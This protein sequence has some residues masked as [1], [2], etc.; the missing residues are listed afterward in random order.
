MLLVAMPYLGDLRG[1]RVPAR[2]G[3]HAMATKKRAAPR[4][5]DL[6]G[7]KYLRLLGPL[8][9]GLHGHA[10]ARDRAGNRRLHFDQLVSL[11]LLYFFSPVLTSLR[12]L[13]Q[14]SDLA[15][16]QRT[17]GVPRLGLGTLSEGSRAFDP[18]LLRPLLGTLAAEAVPVVAGRE[19][20]A[21]RQLTAVDGSLLPALPRMAWALWQDADHRAAKMHVQF[22]VLKGVPCDATVTTGNGSER[23]QLR[24]MLRPGRLYVIDRGYVDYALF[25]DILEAGSSFIGRVCDDV[26]FR[27][28]E[29]RP[30]TAEATSAGVIRD[31]VVSRLGT[32]HHKDEL[33][34]AVRLVLVAT[35]KTRPDGTAEVLILCTDRLDL[36]AELVALGYKFRWSVE[37]FFRWLKCILGCRHLLF[38]SPRGVALQVYVALIASVLVSLWTGHKPTKRTYE[39]L[40]FYF[41]GMASLEELLAHIEKL[42][43]PP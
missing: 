22:E 20:E 33:H 3:G 16:V 38:E 40:C 13:R 1:M 36:A 24:A 43:E 7:F 26:A 42:Q 25:H 29:E 6:Q 11:L 28:A 23:D 9:E 14:A 17:L 31:V 2:P 8:L 4:E 19:A 15:K 39:M 34:R 41:S 21:L 37:L 5:E 32:D 18:E 12:G 27:V 10:T 30:L 35:G